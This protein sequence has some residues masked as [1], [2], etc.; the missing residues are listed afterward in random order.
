MQ[1]L[2]LCY[3]AAMSASPL[4]ELTEWLLDVVFP[5]YCASCGSEGSFFCPACRANLNFGAP[6][7]LVCSRRNFTGILC[8]SCAKKTGIRRFLAPFSYRDESVRKLIHAY[9]YEGIR[10]LAPLFA[11]E[12]TA[13]LSFYGARPR[14]GCVLVPIPLHRSRERERGFNQAE[15]LSRELEARLGIGVVMPLERVRA[16]EHQTLMESYGARRENISGAFRVQD[17]G[18]VRERTVILVDD[19]ATSGATLS[20]AARALREAGA[21]SVWALTIAKG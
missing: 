17:P 1:I 15:L 3:N 8:G 9:K 5:K 4:T 18:A 16:T 21:K 2:P 10:D 11:D 14:G 6:S 13:F 20:E 19:V 7:C 12:L